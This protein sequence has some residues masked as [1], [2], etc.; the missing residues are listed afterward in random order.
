M[1]FHVGIQNK[2]KFYLG[3]ISL[4]FFSSFGKACRYDL[5]DVTSAAYRERDRQTGPTFPHL[6]ERE[7]K[8]MVNNPQEKGRGFGCTYDAN[9]GASF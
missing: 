7:E 3:G 1:P 2:T 9:R 5:T 6:K 8:E 4:L